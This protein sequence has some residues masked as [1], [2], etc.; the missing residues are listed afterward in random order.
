MDTHTGA[1][2]RRG[3]SNLVQTLLIPTPLR[4][5]QGPPI[6]ASMRMRNRVFSNLRRLLLSMD[7]VVVRTVRMSMNLYSLEG[8]GVSSSAPAYTIVHIDHH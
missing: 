5:S 7:L 3:V 2:Q 8:L 4:W 1:P 6:G